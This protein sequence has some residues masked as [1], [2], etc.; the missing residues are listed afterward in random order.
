[1]RGCCANLNAGGHGGRSSVTLRFRLINFKHQKHRPPE[2]P[3]WRD[4]GDQPASNNGPQTATHRWPAAIMR[5]Y[6][7]MLSGKNRL[8]RNVKVR[9]TLAQ[10]VDSVE[11]DDAEVAR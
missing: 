1:L 8:L 11:H 2:W 10:P 6:P 3:Q 7:L 4:H 5:K 9:Y